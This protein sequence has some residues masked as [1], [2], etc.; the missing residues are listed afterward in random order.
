MTLPQSSPGIRS[1]AQEVD[2]TTCHNYGTKK[3]WIRLSSNYQQNSPTMGK[4]KQQSKQNGE[5]YGVLK[6]G[7]LKV[8]NNESQQVCEWTIDLNDYDVSIYPPGRQEHTLF[9]RSVALRLQRKPAT[10]TKD[11]AYDN[12][13]TPT[14][15]QD[16]EIFFSC[17]RPIDK[18]D[19]YFGFVSVANSLPTSRRAIPFDPMAVA[20][21]ITFVGK[22]NHPVSEQNQQQQQQEQQRIPWFNA[23]LGRTFLG[24]YKTQRLQHFVFETLA[25]KT[26]KMKTPGFLGDIQVRSVDLGH[27]IPFVTN[28]TL[29]A[30]H[31][32]GTLVLDAQVD[33]N[34]GFK[35]VV[36]TTVG[37]T[38]SIRVPLLLSL[39]LRSLSGTIRFKIKPPPSNRYWIG[40][41]TMPTMKWSIV[42]A[43]SNCNVK[44]SMVT[45]IIESKIRRLMTENMVLPNME[46][47]P[48]AKS[49]G[50]GGIFH[51][52]TLDSLAGAT[53]ST[54]GDLALDGGLQADPTIP[55]DD[56]LDSSLQQS[57]IIN[58]SNDQEAVST[59]IDPYS[60]SSPSSGRWSK[61]FNTRRRK[62][63]ASS[64]TPGPSSTTPSS[65]PL[66]AS[67]APSTT[68]PSSTPSTSSLAP[69]ST[70]QHTVIPNES[71]K[72]N[73][74]SYLSIQVC[75]DMRGGND[76]HQGPKLKANDVRDHIQ[77]DTTRDINSD[78]DDTDQ[79]TKERTSN[80][81]TN[82]DSINGSKKDTDI[83][84]PSAVLGG[85]Y[86]ISPSGTASSLANLASS[87]TLP[88]DTVADPTPPSDNDLAKDDDGNSITSTKSTRRKRIYNAAGYIF[89]KGKGLANE[90]R[91]HRQQD[92]QVK[93]QQSL[94]H[95]NDQL[96]DMRRRCNEN[97]TRRLSTS[98]TS[99][100]SSSTMVDS[101]HQGPSSETPSLRQKS[102]PPL[103]LIHS[104]DIPATYDLTPQDRCASDD[105]PPL[106]PRRP[107][108]KSAPPPLS[109]SPP[110]LHSFHDNSD[111][112]I[113]PSP[114]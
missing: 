63:T 86:H 79:G 19:W 91:D 73:N 61:F 7:I 85:P 94:L 67:L 22:E 41:C 106:P 42:P 70:T 76:D 40:F 80:A 113:H 38:F 27:A 29:V 93:R 84:N 49:D 16:K 75:N 92:L 100:S 109:S 111:G 104:D 74:Q 33:Y 47:I 36:E 68:T 21:L 88:T 108:R 20:S 81:D 13:P 56:D 66:T 90:L 24:I 2:V 6:Q 72:N 51:N 62:N 71:P 107:H 43:V 57:F 45:K 102:I 110:S 32:D 87:K 28:P 77:S 44:I 26:A 97:T 14:T 54:G 103:H 98:S 101:L 64:G 65:T 4:K 11:A 89:S 78:D 58:G 105:K 48:F 114:R 52:P 59:S 46:D 37:G 35:V 55:N 69:S 53:D 99:S 34:G 30:L 96:Q 1:V 15:T 25:K 3:G 5:G 83:S 10:D 39:T 112:D 82:N 12:S 60:T 23:V 18:E 95:Y 17:T 50:L 9:S 31:P 8:Y